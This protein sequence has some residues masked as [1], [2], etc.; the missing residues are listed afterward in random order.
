VTFQFEG[1]PVAAPEPSSFLLMGVG[2]IC[3]LAYRLRQSRRH[4]E[5]L[6]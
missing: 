4:A 5:T 3:M 6:T 2:A 1:T